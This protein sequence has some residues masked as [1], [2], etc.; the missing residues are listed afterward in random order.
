M[1]SRPESRGPFGQRHESSRLVALAKRF[2]AL[3][4]KNAVHKKGYFVVPNLVKRL[5]SQFDCI[6]C[7]MLSYF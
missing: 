2:A 5:V 1:H 6:L 3:E 7:T 4:T